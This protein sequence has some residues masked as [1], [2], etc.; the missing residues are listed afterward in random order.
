MDEFP[1]FVLLP[2]FKPRPKLLPL[3]MTFFQLPGHLH[4]RDTFGGHQHQDVI[5]QVS[6]L[7]DETLVL[8]RERSHNHLGAFFADFLGNERQAFGKQGGRIRDLLVEFSLR[9][10]IIL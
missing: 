4:G 6:D 10:R 2:S 1:G 8:L 5:R 7:L 9:S 3:F